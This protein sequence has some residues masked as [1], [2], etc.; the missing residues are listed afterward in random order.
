[1]ALKVLEDVCGRLEERGPAGVDVLGLA[2][3]S[4][5]L[6]KKSRVS[7]FLLTNLHLEM[8]DLRRERLLLVLGPVTDLS[9]LVGQGVDPRTHA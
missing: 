1:M 4:L 7:N 8:G 3:Q 2:E 5:P 9:E 6:L